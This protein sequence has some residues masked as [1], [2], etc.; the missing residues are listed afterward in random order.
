MHT[1]MCADLTFFL[2]D[3]EDVCVTALSVGSGTTAVA[4]LKEKASDD[5]EL[6]VLRPLY[7]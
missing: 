3:C 7:T 5:R 1:H 2:V 4:G 6:L